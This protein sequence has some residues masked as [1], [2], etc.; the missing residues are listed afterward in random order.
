MFAKLL[1]MILLK[2]SAGSISGC[3]SHM[4][5][6]GHLERSDK[7]R[8]TLYAGNFWRDTSK[9]LANNTLEP[10]KHAW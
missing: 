10:L 2:V 7:C 3:A 5:V 4:E 1:F 9:M 8:G 6:K